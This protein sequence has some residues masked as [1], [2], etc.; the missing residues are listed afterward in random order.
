MAIVRYKRSQ[1]AGLLLRPLGHGYWGVEQTQ[2][3]FTFLGKGGKQVQFSDLSGSPKATKI[4][5]F[6]AVSF[7][8]K[9]GPDVEIVGLQKAGRTLP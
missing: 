1:L 3:G 9:Y 7:P 2:T 4:L 8:L 5:G 6:R